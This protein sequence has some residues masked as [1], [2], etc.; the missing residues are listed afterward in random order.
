MILVTQSFFEVYSSCI[1][2]FILSE[3]KTISKIV[4]TSL[5]TQGLLKI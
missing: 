5:P 1:Q 2:P 4:H 3:P